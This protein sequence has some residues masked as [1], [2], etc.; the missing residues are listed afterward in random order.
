MIHER[1]YGGAVP[2]YYG[3]IV[4]HLFMGTAALMLIA[5]PFYADTLRIELPFEIAGALALVALAALAN[6]HR[7][8]VFIGSAV[9]S[10]TGVIIYATW[11]LYTYG[12]STPAQFILRQLIAVLFLIAFYF[13]IKTVR[14]FILDRVGKDEVPGEFEKPA[15]PEPEVVLKD[16][17]EEEHYEEDRPTHL[18]DGRNKNMSYLE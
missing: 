6:P 1:P 5:A 3:D 10:G 17:E 12:S 14:A 9:V 4:R 16:G 18:V 2:H 13:S 8:S 11:A 15:T 7:K